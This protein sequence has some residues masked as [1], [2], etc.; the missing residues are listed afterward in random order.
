MAAQDFNRTA[1]FGAITVYN[2]VTK[3]ETLWNTIGTWNK[4]RQT[5]ATLNSL[6][7]REL[8]DIGLSRNDVEAFA[9]RK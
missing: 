8:E 5:I 2:T 6:S 4:R 9:S 1:P 3:V 7:S